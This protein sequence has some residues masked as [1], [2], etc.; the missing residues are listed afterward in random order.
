ML[1]FFKR[2]GV[3]FL[4]MVMVLLSACSEVDKNYGV[5]SKTDNKKTPISEKYKDVEIP[6]ISSD[7]KV[8]PKYL[9]ISLYDV[10]N[11]ADIYL[12]A[13]FKYN[14][15]YN[16]VKVT[17]PSTYEKLADLGFKTTNSSVTAESM[18]LADEKIEVPFKT[19]DGKLLTVTFH[20]SKTSSQAL[21]KC[22]IVK[23][24]IAENTLET[25]NA[26]YGEF[27]V[28]G[29]SNSSSINDIIETLGAPSHFYAVSEEVYYLDYFLNK[30]D[31]RDRITVYVNTIDDFVISVEVSRYS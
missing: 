14:I 24:N 3:I 20:N 28:N 7:D 27:A 31:K 22:K 9:D 15:T 11:Y 29:V 16:N 21:K 5:E 25:G 1:N 6:E 10:E 30:K 18:V 23:I 13:K 8:M 17:L 19:S 4:V 2:V 12:G 26:M